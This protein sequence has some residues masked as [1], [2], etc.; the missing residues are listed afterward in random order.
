[1]RGVPR[2]ATAGFT[3]LET[4]VGLTLLGLMLILIYA[5]LS[6]GLRAWD[7]GEKRVTEA[8]H[9][10]VVQSFLR[11]ELSQLFPV[12]W[13]GIPES[14][15][16]FEGGK[17]E[18]KFV[19]MLTLGAAAREGGMQWGHLYIADVQ[20]PGGESRRALF[21][22]RSAFNLQA[23]DWDGLDEAKPIALIE[24]V[25][26]FDIGYYGAEND[27]AEPQWTDEWTNA[28]RMPQLIKITLQLDNGRDV[29]PLVVSLRLGEE[30][31]CYD[32]AFQR[33]CGAR[34]A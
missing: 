13:R 24:G 26:S 28:L 1:M 19:T 33:A 27:T 7:T 21:I 22:K 3:L 5:S 17:N 34:R 11:R 6:I 23:K 4:L 8:S 20:S 14:K 15:I 30:A 2:T 29:P 10:R 32:N 18:L 9:Q 31:G 12:R 16:A 25:K